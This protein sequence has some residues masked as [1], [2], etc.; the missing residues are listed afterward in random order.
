MTAGPSTQPLEIA[1]NDKT[2]RVGVVGLGYVGLPLIRAF[3]DAGYR[4]LGFDVDQRK[5]D[6]LQ[7]GKSY[8]KHI[9]GDWIAGWLIIVLAHFLPTL[10]FAGLVRG[11]GNRYKRRWI[12]PLDLRKTARHLAMNR[13]LVPC[14][15]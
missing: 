1:I 3:I 11:R 4:T 7:S 6:Q 14:N 9:P 10:H 15:G 8:I 2:A 5:V 13:S 12:L